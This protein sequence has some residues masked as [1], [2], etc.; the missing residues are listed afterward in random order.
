MRKLLFILSLLVCA[1]V[2]A[3]PTNYTN[4]NGRYRWIAGVFDSTFHI[5]KEQVQV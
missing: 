4:I 1:N 3:Q 2:Y 5:P